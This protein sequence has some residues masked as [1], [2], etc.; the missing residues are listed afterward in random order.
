MIRPARPADAQAIT[1]LWNPIIRD[2]VITFDP[3]QKPVAE[4]LA[5]IQAPPPGAFLV[6]EQDGEI[7]GFARFFQFRGGLGYAHTMEHTINLAPA[8]RGQGLGRALMRALEDAARA[9]SAHSMIAA[10]TASNTGSVAF[11]AALG[12]AHVG[13]VP[14]AGWKFGQWHDLVLMQKL[15]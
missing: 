11:H 13:F 4:I 10:V 14:Q 1:D 9:Q 15:L 6:A 3:V 12:Y 2:T 7:L 5:M 8:A